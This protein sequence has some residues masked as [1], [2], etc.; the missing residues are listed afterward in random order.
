MHGTQGLVAIRV[1]LQT[2]WNYDGGTQLVE[3]SVTPYIY[4]Y[5]HLYIYNANTSGNKRDASS[6]APLLNTGSGLSD[7]YQAPATTWRDCKCGE[8]LKLVQ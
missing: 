4:N 6:E 3:M 1:S 7:L 2:V 8:V 5:I